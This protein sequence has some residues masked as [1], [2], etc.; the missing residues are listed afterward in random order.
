MKKLYYGDAENI[1]ACPSVMPAQ[2]TRRQVTASDWSCDFGQPCSFHMSVLLS[3]LCLPNYFNKMSPTCIW[4]LALL[5][6]CIGG[7][8][9][10]VVANV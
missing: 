8:A 3:V 6:C 9:L 10:E 1:P 4:P 5:Y 2:L 7:R